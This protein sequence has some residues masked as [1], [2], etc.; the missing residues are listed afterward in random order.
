MLPDTSYDASFYNAIYMLIEDN[1]D[2]AHKY[3]K[4]CRSIL[5][6]E[7]KVVLGEGY[8]RAYSHHILSLQQLSEME[9]IIRYKQHPETREQLKK[10]W[11][12]RLNGC[13]PDVDTWHKILS[14]RAVAVAPKDD[15]SVW[16]K[17][18]GLCRKSEK[19][20]LMT[21][22]LKLIS[23]EN[24]DAKEMAGVQYTCIK[25]EWALGNKEYALDALKQLYNNTFVNYFI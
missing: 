13:K 17:F 19:F 3:I 20:S 6:P 12:E 18:A 16:K 4:T 21:Y 9:E 7:T 8:K 11:Q 25:G 2:K 14:V 15:P 23:P 1:H 22:I 10:I 5:D 24:V